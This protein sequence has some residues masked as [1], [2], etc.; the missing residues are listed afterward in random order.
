[1]SDAFCDDGDRE[2]RA[3]S[4]TVRYWS[5]HGINENHWSPYTSDTRLLKKA[6]RIYQKEILDD[7]EYEPKHMKVTK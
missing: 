4:R 2:Y 3:V 6:Y 1:M 7:T 5:E